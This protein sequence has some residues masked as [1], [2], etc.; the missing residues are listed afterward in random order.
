MNRLEIELPTLD[1]NF[2]FRARRV[3]LGLTQR[4]LGERAGVCKCTVSRVER[5]FRVRLEILRR[6]APH[7][8]I[9]FAQALALFAIQIGERGVFPPE[10]E[11]AP[12]RRGHG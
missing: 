2:P 3:Q 12:A 5:G 1:S 4:E 10:D 9:S 11:A 8:H 6:L 7:L